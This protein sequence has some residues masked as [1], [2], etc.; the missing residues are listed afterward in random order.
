VGGGAAV[1]WNGW[2]PEALARASSEGKLIFLLIGPVWCQGC[3]LLDRT[4]LAD[5]RVARMLN[6]D[7]IAVRVDADRRP[8]VHERYNQGGWP[9]TAVLLPD[10]KL[11]TGATYLLPDALAG[12]LEKCRDFYRRDRAG[13]EAYMRH[14]AKAARDAGG[15]REDA[16]AVPGADDFPRVRRAVLSAYDPVHPGFFREPKFPMTDILGF[17]R[18]AWFVEGDAESGDILLRVLRTMR[19]SALFDPVEGG[20]F[21]YAARRDWTA[22]QCEKLLPDNA[23]LLG[24]CAAA[25]GKMREAVFAETG[26]D[27]LRFLFGKLHDP[28]SGAF[29]GSQYADEGY[30]RLPAAERARGTPPAVDR[31]VFSEY[32][33]RM[34]SA[35]VAAHRAFGPPAGADAAGD[36]LLARAERLAGFLRR[37]LWRGEEGQARYQAPP[38]AAETP[39]HG[40]LSDHAAVATAHLDLFDITG[41]EDFLRHAE[42]ALAFLVAHLY[43][44]PAA[45]FVDRRPA[46]GDF[47]GLATPVFPFAANAHAASALLRCARAAGRR[48]LFRVGGRVL[49]GLSAESDRQ[50]AFAAPYGSAL[51]LY[52]LQGGRGTL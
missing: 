31:T 30:H 42:E 20:F 10:G 2:E 6:G 25:Y 21:R 29:F 9:T 38:G 3:R 22:P 8:D 50:G 44:E 41:K 13:V 48:D 40:L 47:G 18:D 17:L 24:L 12:V 49:C 26:R 45:G 1:R 36:S 39:P 51:L 23:D 35:L 15:A 33:G 5:P 7:F 34:A 4:S 11:L 19:S 14:G 32:N 37:A 52:R 46:D 16:P 27:I 43:R 28:G